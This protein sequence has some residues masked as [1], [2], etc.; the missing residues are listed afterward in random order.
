[1]H[2]LLLSLAY[3]GLPLLQA[4][5]LRDIELFFPLLRGER[6][7]IKNNCTTFVNGKLGTVSRVV[8]CVLEIQKG[9]L[10]MVNMSKTYI[11]LVENVF[12]NLDIAS[13]FLSE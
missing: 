3:S 12:D 5:S 11:F 1:M 4:G 10:N 6:P 2:G 9:T 7:T 8:M 13:A